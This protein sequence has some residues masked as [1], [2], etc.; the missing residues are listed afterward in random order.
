MFELLP[1]WVVE[2]IGG[3]E[4][5]STGA[6][7]GRDYRRSSALLKTA[8]GRDRDKWFKWICRRESLK[9]PARQSKRGRIRD[10]DGSCLRLRAASQLSMSRS[11]RRSMPSAEI[12]D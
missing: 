8:S 9:V 2:G 3:Y 5:G 1:S 11:F 7:P 4:A 12:V 10:G 6:T